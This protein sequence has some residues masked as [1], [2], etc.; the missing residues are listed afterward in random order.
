M[1]KATSTHTDLTR[2]QLI[3]K[4]LEI[5]SE[6]K[7]GRLSP[8]GALMV[9]TGKH[10]GRAAK[11]RFVVSH[12]SLAKT[13]DWG[14][15]NKPIDVSLANKFFLGLEK[16]LSEAGDNFQM[17]GFVGAFPVKVTSTSPWHIAFAKN[18]F[19]DSG[20]ASVLNLLP[21]GQTIEIFHDPYGKISKDY[22]LDWDSDTAG[23]TLIVLD[24][25]EMRVGITGTAYAGEIKKSAFSACNYLLPAYGIFPMHA[26][27]NCEKDGSNSS[28]LFG[29]SGTGKTT[30][31]ADPNR[32][33]I[34]DDEI[35]WTGNGLSN[36]EGGCYAKLIN[37]S[38]EAEPEIHSAC[39][40]P[41]T[42]LENVTFDESSNALD[43]DD[44]SKTE[45][46]RGSYDI[47]VLSNVFEQTR[48]SDSPK[49]N[50]FLTADAFG[51]FPAVARLD[52]WQAQYHFISGYTA[53]VAGTE[54]G[55][56]EPTAA[57]SACFGAPFMPRHPTVYAEMLAA[58][59]KQTNAT[60]WL[61]NTGWV[62]GAQ[63]GE[64]FP[65]KVSR[66]LLTAIQNGELAKQDTVRHPVFGFEV[67]TSCPGV[68]SN[69]LSLPKGA[70]VEALAEK[71]K[72]NFDQFIDVV[73]LD[74]A[75]KGGPHAQ[76]NSS[77][78]SHPT[79]SV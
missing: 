30:L 76:E 50:V 10:T 59:A 7:T 44:S 69:W 66:A 48:E 15:V 71:F 53:K 37:L 57:F 38:K 8:D 3:E 42:I 75:V 67:P 35:I 70:H 43:F 23:D 55:V 77:A 22:D 20:I 29:L 72:K 52:F 63:K 21:E 18:M 33:L 12:E 58:K 27:A 40:R 16:R 65:I 47:S 39:H 74:V 62:G 28:V 45:N 9:D 13:V 56:T 51:A 2:S 26:S 60:V 46:T 61:L 11:H 6:I 19:R 68:D 25:E 17:N 49:T 73:E 41:E 36:L 54:L 78:T 32:A 79:I 34:G 5:K 64:R 31:S 1:A 24:L 14:K 4:T